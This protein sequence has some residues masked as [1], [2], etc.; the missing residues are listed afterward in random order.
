MDLIGLHIYCSDFNMCINRL[1]AVEL[2][3]GLIPRLARFFLTAIRIAIIFVLYIILLPF[4]TRWVLSNIV[5]VLL[6]DG[7]SSDNA[8]DQ[9][10][11]NFRRFSLKQ[12]LDVVSYWW[13]GVL[14][15]LFILGCSMSVV[16]GVHYLRNEINRN[17]TIDIII[18]V[19]E[20]VNEDNAG[21]IRHNG[22]NREEEAAFDNIDND[23]D[24]EDIETLAGD[25]IGPQQLREREHD[26]DEE[27]VGNSIIEN[28]QPVV[29]E[30]HQGEEDNIFPLNN[31]QQP[32]EDEPVPQVAENANDLMNNDNILDEDVIVVEVGEIL[33]GPLLKTLLDSFLIMFFNFVFLVATVWLPTM[34]GRVFINFAGLRQ[35]LLTESSKVVEYISHQYDSNETMKE[36]LA[37]HKHVNKQDEQY[38]NYFVV[39]TE[40]VMGWSFVVE[41]LFA[42]LVIILIIRYQNHNMA[43]H[44]QRGEQGA[45]WQIS[46]VSMMRI[47]SKI[48]TLLV[49]LKKFFKSS[50]FIGIEYALPQLIG[51]I[52]DII[53]LK[54]LNASLAARLSF[55]HEKPLIGGIIHFLVG[56]SFMSHVSVCRQEVRRVLRHDVLRY[57]AN[58]MNVIDLI[59]LLMILQ[60]S[61]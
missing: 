32:M 20:T 11:S 30:V 31:A 8:F 37:D 5:S 61:Y 22:D 53:M 4:W 18:N 15:C 10:F 33:S 1:S 56:I 21:D 35:Y 55:F 50:L 29:E 12:L 46:N 13:N 27:Y 43:N 58:C 47:R 52:I 60:H 45:W 14:V 19:D 25:E 24:T 9:D 49:E 42:T 34:F 38:T 26:D 36:V 3:A 39:F 28:H 54:S 59:L 16:Q 48:S 57:V 40:F 2:L 51:W 7:G 6:M 23:D 17:D 41:L 44:R